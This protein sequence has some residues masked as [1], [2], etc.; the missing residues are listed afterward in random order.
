MEK[1]IKWILGE[2]HRKD[3]RELL[4]EHVRKIT[5]D[6]NNNVVTVSIDKRYII[7]LLKSSRY[8]TY[9]IEGVRRY[10]WKKIQIHLRL[11][12]PHVTHNREMLI[13]LFVHY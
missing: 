5:F 11:D 6:E 2:I 7:N 4:E 3:L 8:I 1:D 13:P 12:H 9:F 10:F